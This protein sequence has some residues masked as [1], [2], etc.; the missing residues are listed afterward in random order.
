MLIQNV[1]LGV[2]DWF[3]N[4]HRSPTSP[5]R[6]HSVT[7][8]ERRVLCWPVSIDELA[9]LQLASGFDHLRYRER[10]PAGQQLP[11][12]FQG[13][14]LGIHHLMKEPSCKPKRA[15]PF[16]LNGPAELLKSG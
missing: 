1:D 11:H 8:S 13:V 4:R 9:I 7:A 3:A 15:D 6:R 2:T 16:L 10:L 12:S 5:S 14:H